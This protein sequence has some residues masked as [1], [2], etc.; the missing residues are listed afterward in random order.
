MKGAGTRLLGGRPEIVNLECCACLRDAE[1]PCGEPSLQK[2]GGIAT[3]T[4]PQRMPFVIR[5]IDDST[6]ILVSRKNNRS[7][8]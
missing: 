3:G 7:L 5:D 2:F 6:A 8:L 1:E 4:S